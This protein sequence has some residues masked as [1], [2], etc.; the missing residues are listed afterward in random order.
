MSPRVIPRILL[1]DDDPDICENL[2]DILSDI[3]YHVET[4]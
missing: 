2:K 4:A 3:G 1:V